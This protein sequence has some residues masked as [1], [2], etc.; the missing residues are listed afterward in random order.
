MIR[1]RI[2]DDRLGPCFGLITQVDHAHLAGQL[3]QHLGTSRYHCPDKFPAFLAATTHHD[4]GWPLHDDAPTLN[5]DGYPTDVFEMPHALAFRVWSPAPDIAREKAAAT[6]DPTSTTP[7]F[8]ELLVSLHILAL[9]GYV[10]DHSP[11][12]R[13][14]KSDPKALPARFDLNKFQHKEIERQEHL[15][16]TLGLNT[17]LPLSLGLA[18][19]N[20][21]PREDHLR[22]HIRWLQALDLISLALCCTKPPAHAS[23]EIHPTPG[24]QS[25][26]LT[27]RRE[28]NDLIIRPWPFA[29]QSIEVQTPMTLIPARSYN[30]EQDLHQTLSTAPTTTLQATVRAF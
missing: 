28:D 9:S 18:D 12:F 3:A 14:G 21:D 17:E 23:P 24:D 26:H 7:A 19:E 30:S 27:L 16:R 20:L 10:A 4:A 1:R 15:R 6:A 22:F 8:A 29:I 25:E 5:R 11:A 13:S 2:V